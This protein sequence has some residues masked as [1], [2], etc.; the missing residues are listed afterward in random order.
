MAILMKEW[1]LDYIQCPKCENRLDLDDKAMK[2]SE[3]VGGTLN[4]RCGAKYPIEKNVPNLVF[5]SKKTKS[6][7]KQVVDTYNKIWDS[8]PDFGMDQGEME[9]SIDKWMAQK[10]G[11]KDIDEL[12][13]FITGKKNILEVGVGAGQKL[14]MMAE[15]TEGKVLGLDIS[16]AAY[17]SYANTKGL[18]NVGIVRAN[19]FS[20]PFKE[21][22]FDFI[23]SDGVLHHTHNTKKAF[24]SIVPLLKEGGE[25]FIRVYNRSGPIREFCD[26]YIRSHTTA[27][28]E[29]EC[30]EFSRKMAEFGKA[31]RKLN[32]TIEIPD[33]IPVLGLKKGKADLQRFFYYNIFKCFYNELYSM[34]ENALVNFDW[35]RPKDAH[36]HTENE[37]M[38]WFKEAGLKN[39]R[40][41]HPESGIAAI[42]QK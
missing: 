25:I 20:A 29:E 7:D 31:L 39:V 9:K 14:K 28:T 16:S 36:R 34:E 33:D 27:M 23:V 40:I 37:V 3:I 18:P 10:L 22:E 6:T 15:H 12:Y 19:L 30:L 38:S 32:C 11:M 35:Y 5:Q 41:Y 4:C 13:E 26:D 17:H 24:M 42:G 21:N 1:L 8:F 2:G